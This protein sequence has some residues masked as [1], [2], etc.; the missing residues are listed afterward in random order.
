MPYN[1]AS[2]KMVSQLKYLYTQGGQRTLKERQCLGKQHTDE[3]VSQT[4]ATEVHSKDC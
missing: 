4:E 1:L 3:P 2:L